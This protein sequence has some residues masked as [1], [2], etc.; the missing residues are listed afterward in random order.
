MNLIGFI[1]LFVSGFVFVFVFVFEFV[2]VLPLIVT[3]I[4]GWQN[5]YWE[6]TTHHMA[7]SAQRTYRNFVFVFVFVLYTQI[8]KL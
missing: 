3:I 5:P 2:F 8:S 1:F 6:I 4:T 7:G